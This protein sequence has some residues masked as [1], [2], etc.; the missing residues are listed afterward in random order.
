[1]PVALA[2]REA[3]DREAEEPDPDGS[4]PAVRGGAGSVSRAFGPA[5]SRER[6]IY[7]V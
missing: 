2:V 3:C 4:V 1:M 5:K 6:P 7:L